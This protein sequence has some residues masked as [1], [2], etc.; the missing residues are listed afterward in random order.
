MAKFHRPKLN[1]WLLT[2]VLASIGLHGLVLALPMPDLAEVPPE[3]EE[4]ADSEII[5]VVTLPKLATGPEVVAQPLPPKPPEKPLPR[6]EPGVDIVITDPEILEEIEPELVEVED[7]FDNGELE[8]EFN[9]DTENGGDIPDEGEEDPRELTL[10]QRLA[11]RDS[12]QNFNGAKVGNDYASNELLNRSLKPGGTWPT[13][14]HALARELPPIVVPLQDCLEDK[15]G[16][17]ITVV[18][19]IGPDAQIIGAPE[20]INSTGYEVLD[21]KALQIAREAD[22]GPHHDAGETKDYAFAIKVDYEA[23]NVAF[24]LANPQAAS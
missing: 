12:Y 4:L 11:S 19:R 13:P 22:Y 15:P 17:S 2:L 20:A 18:V 6:T 5:Q 3:T 14:L 24:Y 7:D 8:N 9:H 1:N 10:A 16:D 21:E 23:C